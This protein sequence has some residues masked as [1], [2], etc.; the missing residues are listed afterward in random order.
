MK[1]VST[2]WR[3]PNGGIPQIVNQ[4]TSFTKV[5]SGLS[6]FSPRCFLITFSFTRFE[7]LT[8]SKTGAPLLVL[9]TSDFT[10]WPTVHPIDFAA[11]SVVL[12]VVSFWI[13]TDQISF[14]SMKSC[15]FCALGWRGVSM[16]FNCKIYVKF[17]I[18]FRWNTLLC[19]STLCYIFFLFILISD[20]S[21]FLG[22][23]KIWIINLASSFGSM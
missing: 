4:V 21:I 13:T 6:I 23:S 8:K 18:Y 1:I 22:S 11:S 9:N 7:P 14:W 5:A 3:C 12:A 19:V 16:V 17:K 10:I 2:S 15:T 20:T